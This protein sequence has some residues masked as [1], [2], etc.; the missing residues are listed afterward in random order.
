MKGIAEGSKVCKRT[1]YAVTS[2]MSEQK[3]VKVKVTI[4]DETLADTKVAEK[5]YKE[6]ESE[7]EHLL[8]RFEMVTGC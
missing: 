1:K 6:F 2:N 8:K 4:N 5:D 7:L 3:F